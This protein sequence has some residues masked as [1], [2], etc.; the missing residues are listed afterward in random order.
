MYVY[1]VHSGV[2]ELDVFRRSEGIER[3]NHAKEGQVY[4]RL[5][6]V[7]G[8]WMGVGKCETYSGAG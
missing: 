4:W 7:G 6:G 5:R 3:V 1:P 2:Y 8:V